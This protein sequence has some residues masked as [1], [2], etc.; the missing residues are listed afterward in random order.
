M[1]TR[2]LPVRMRHRIAIWVL[3]NV[4]RDVRDTWAGALNLSVARIRNAVTD[5][6]C[7]GAPISAEMIVFLPEPYRG[8]LLAVLAEWGDAIDRGDL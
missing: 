1:R 2:G 6:R 3:Q 8:G 5:G 4:P 7:E